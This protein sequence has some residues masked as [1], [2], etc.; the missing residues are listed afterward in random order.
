MRKKNK[1]EES[2]KGKI[3]FYVS[4]L[5]AVSMALL[6]A[7]TI[8]MNY[9]ST[10][11]TL[12]Q[13]MKETAQ[14]AAERVGYRISASVNVVKEVGSVARFSSDTVSLEDK[15]AIIDQKIN[16]YNCTRAGILGTDGKDIF[17]GADYSDRT[18][19]QEAMKGN[20]YVSAP[21]IVDGGRTEI[22]VA[23]PLWQGGIPDTTVAGCVY[24]VPEE[25]YLDNMVSN[26]KVSES[27]SAYII[28]RDGYT[29]A[30]KNH[31]QVVA[32]ENTAEEA[33]TDKGLK[34]LA[35]LEARMAA[36]EFGFGS[37]SYGGVHKFLAF[38]PIPDMDGW[39]L[40]VNAPTND[41]MGS[42]ILGIIITVV[43]LVVSLVIAYFII[44]K[45][46]DGI[47]QPVRRCADRL[48]LLAEGDLHS[49]VPV[50]DS[51][52]ETG[53]LAEATGQIVAV[54]TSVIKDISY[55]LENMSQG[56]FRVSSQARN[57]YLGDLAGILVSEEDIVKKLSGAMSGIREA[58]DQVS[59]GSTQLAESAQTLAEGATDQASGVE[60][61]LATV[62]DVTEQVIRNSEEAGVTSQDA[63][64]M[65]AEAQQSNAQMEQMT[66]AMERISEKSKQIAAIIGSIEEIA[67]QTNLLSLNA[68]IEAARAG[69]AGKGFAVVADEIRELAN[70][71]AQAVV[72]TRKLID[73]TIA[74]VQSG[75]GI[76]QGTAG[77]L[78]DL[79]A[80]LGSIVTAI[81]RV[82]EASAQQ[83]EM[84]K[85]LNQGIEQISNIVQSNSASAQESSATSEEL[86]AQAVTLNELVAQFKLDE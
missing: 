71:S 21:E 73:D 5:M 65:G 30:H 81:E 36:G 82:G 33:K 31:D 13:T 63:R 8:L 23:A 86:S 9:L 28:D 46:A 69:E 41:F 34:E 77:S 45:L 10:N 58:A 62:N 64:R 57:S 32:H 35:A 50:I 74:E 6:G 56:N 3:R 78:S 83:A 60:E 14:V 22:Y 75:N 54:I 44:V 79:I 15:K 55:V 59:S 24:I 85:Q 53:I 29:I 42:T 48:R 18:F 39:S 11:S 80:G 38:A 43:I 26:I 12:E 61:L 47:G 17:N 51:R 7:I 20:T 52:D 27:G 84:M 66:Q 25:L 19:F 49:E 70:Q 40:G 37:Y 2:I 72:D 68:A 4:L 16:T 76:V 67:S 1:R